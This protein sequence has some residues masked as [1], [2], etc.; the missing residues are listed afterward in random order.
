MFKQIKILSLGA[1]FLFTLSAP[2]FAAGG[3]DS[4]GASVLEY[5][6]LDPLLLPVIDQDGLQQ[7]VSLIVAIE[8]D[9]VSNADKVK[10]MKPRLTDAYIQDVYGILNE[11]A[12]MKDG[13]IQV[14]KLKQR[15]NDVTA[16]VVGDD[17]DAEVLLQVVQQRPL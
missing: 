4:G 12:A 13:V 17:I 6:K 9:G 5:V 16:H 11:H 1:V 8:V 10:S 15:L 7:V 2:V 14:K 3:G